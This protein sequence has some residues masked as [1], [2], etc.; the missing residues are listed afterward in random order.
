M[1]GCGIC[2][3]C[4]RRIVKKKLSPMLEDLAQELADPDFGSDSL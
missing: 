1:I 3:L 4:G 2:V